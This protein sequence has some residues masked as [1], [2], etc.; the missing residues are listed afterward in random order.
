MS[1]LSPGKPRK[2]TPGKTHLA[3][4]CHQRPRS[5]RVWGG[6]LN[7]PQSDGADCGPW[8][9]VGLSLPGTM[10]VCWLWVADTSLRCLKQKRLEEWGGISGNP[11]I[12]GQPGLRKF[13]CASDGKERCLQGRRPRFNRWM[14]KIPWRTAW[15]RT[16]VSLPGKSHGQ[17]SLVHG[18]AKSRTQLSS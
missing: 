11:G 14:G 6:I 17:R 12:M 16:P 7:P 1:L 15:Q 2:T 4:T 9:S 3:S 5:Q 8:G 13:L 18:V 10:R